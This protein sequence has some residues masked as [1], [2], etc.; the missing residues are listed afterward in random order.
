[1]QSGD[2]IFKD[3][4]KGLH[5]FMRN[6]RLV[7]H[8]AG[9]AYPGSDLFHRWRR[10]RFLLRSMLWWKSTTVWLSSYAAPSSRASMQWHACNL[11]RIHRPFMHSAFAAED[12]LRISLDHQYFTWRLA[13]RIAHAMTTYGSALLASFAA[14]GQTWSLLVESLDRFH[15]EGDWSL[16]IR[17][18]A[19]AR[20]V[21]CT[22]SVGRLAGKVSR[23][24]LLIGCVQGPDTA[25][26]GRELFRAL[27]RQWH[28][29][30]PKPFIVYLAQSLAHEMG[31]SNALLVSN[32]A[33]IYS[34]WRYML[35]KRR[36][37]A[38][39]VA[40]S[41]ECGRV[42]AWNGWLL[43][44]L[45]HN[46]K[47]STQPDRNGRGRT[48]R[49]RGELLAS[50]EAQIRRAVHYSAWLS[51]GAPT[52]SVSVTQSQPPHEDPSAG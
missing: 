45:P 3:P 48:R 42:T 1:M 9:D 47:R 30:R 51:A 10:L 49:L 34:H 8:C 24:R 29:L 20:L 50:V 25:V 27:T 41:R 4:L 22:F 14:S 12:R 21:S 15:E 38:D 2:L 13:P 39:Y 52:P 36:V 16:C 33:H 32:H 11:E 7:W 18:A 35:R 23:P 31:A 19:G 40:L 46:R 28:G 5:A 43:L 26:N 44:G 17:D 6:L 37:K